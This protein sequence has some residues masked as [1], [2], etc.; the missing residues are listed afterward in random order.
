[1]I[2]NDLFWQDAAW[3]EFLRAWQ[4]ER[5]GHALLI[6][7]PEGLGKLQLAFRIAAQVL[8]AAW[9]PAEPPLPP[10]HADLL[11]LTL[12][13][14]EKGPKQQIGVQQVR[15]ACA[16]LAM[17]S[18]TGG[19]KAAVIAPAER[20]TLAAA[21][22]LLKTLEEPAPRTLIVL[23]RSRLDTLPATVASR[24]QRLRLAAP[25][26]DAA[27]AWLDRS[28]PGRPWRRLL[29]LAGGAPLLAAR[30]AERGYAELDAAFADDLLA[31]LAGRADPL[32]IAASWQRRELPDVLRWL[33]IWTCSLVRLKAAG[34]PPA[35]ENAKQRALQTALERIPLQRLYRYLDEVHGAAAR[36]DGALNAQLMLESLLTPWPDRLEPLTGAAT[37]GLLADR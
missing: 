2:I 35:L 37:Q 12:E 10:R 18:Y 26:E 8:G 13:E 36:M 31:I 16:T 21:N 6:E 33:D 3:A 30:L 25:P 28:L 24:C 22:A 4:A 7:G 27:L 20:L 19:W 32:E 11:W 5:L 23:V 34:R 14:G 17:T 9:T 29:E 15:D 1:M